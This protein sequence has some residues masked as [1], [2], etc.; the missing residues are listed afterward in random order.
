MTD[1]EPTIPRLRKHLC[2]YADAKV[3]ADRNQYTQLQNNNGSTGNTLDDSLINHL[4]INNGRYEK[5]SYLGEGQFAVVYLGRDKSDNS[6]VAMKKI[7][8]GSR[9]D[10]RDG[11]N[12]SA[13]REMKLLREL[14]HPFVVNLIDVFLQGYNVVL[15][16]PFMD[17]DLEAVVRDVSI[18]LSPAHIKRYMIMLLEGTDYLHKNF[19]LHRDLK[20]N[21][22]LVD[23]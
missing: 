14:R 7:K 15:L 10:V 18:V 5:L 8:L 6:L 12:R 13:M 23:R 4:S 2:V 17:T 1:V 21:N 3:K 11:I 22:L 16:L 20:P 9:D 19:V